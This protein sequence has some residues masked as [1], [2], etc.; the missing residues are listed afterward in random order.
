[1]ENMDIKDI[2]S[3]LITIYAIVPSIVITVMYSFL[4][5]MESEVS[6]M[7]SRLYDKCHQNSGNNNLNLL[8]EEMRKI[9]R[10]IVASSKILH[11]SMSYYLIQLFCALLA[12]S[13][14]FVD[15][16]ALIFSW[17]GHLM[18]IMYFFMYYQY[19]VKKAFE[20]S[21]RGEDNEGKKSKDYKWIKWYM[22]AVYGFLP[23][24]LFLV[25]FCAW[26]PFNC[27]P[28]E[29]MEVNF[30]LW[31]IAMTILH[32]LLWWLIIPFYYKPLTRLSTIK[33]KTTC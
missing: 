25:L 32:L 27:F 31:W 26:L 19:S 10:F 6:E 13:F 11:Y 33:R 17:A 18:F 22:F 20:L 1:M 15:K 9:D 7:W 4:S 23:L 3:F 16:G 30:H 21:F 5:N 28:F 14:N 12:K 8:K 29:P 24:L 2:V